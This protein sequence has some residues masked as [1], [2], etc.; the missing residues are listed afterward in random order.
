MSVAGAVWT[1]QF[2]SA[3]IGIHTKVNL[4]AIVLSFFLHVLTLFWRVWGIV[5]HLGHC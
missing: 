3:S 2:G 1:V 5:A 4:G